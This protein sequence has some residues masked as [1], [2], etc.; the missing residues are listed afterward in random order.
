MFL[1][2]R[3]FRPVQAVQDQLAKE[4][5][6]RDADRVHIF[7]ALVVHDVD[8][9]AAILL[10][11]QVHV[12]PYFNKSLCSLDEHPSVSPGPQSVR[13]KP[14]QLEVSR[15]SVLSG[16]LGVAEVFQFRIFRMVKVR[17]P[18]GGHDRV[19][20]LRVVQELFK[21]MAADIAQDSAVLLPFKEPCGPSGCAKPVGTESGYGNHLADLSAFR[22]ISGQ[23]GSLVM[24][25]LR[26]V[27]HV[28]LSG[29][30]HC[31]LCG[32][33]LFQGCKRRLVGK[34]VFA[35]VHGPQSQG[36]AF[37]GDSRTG[38]QMRL[39]V[40]QGFFLAPGCLRLRKCLQEGFNLLLIRIIYIFERAAGLGQAVAH[41]V[42]M[43]V[44][45]PYCGKYEFS[46][47]YHRLGL[48]FRRIVHSV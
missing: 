18:A 9:S 42:N 10:R 6:S 24:Q 1:R 43:A 47:F 25:P 21:L 41:P 40:S 16:Q 15:R 34:V 23:D 37:A 8:V 39:R 2:H 45:Q 13:G 46:R 30:R 17:D 33:Q 7:F 27:H 5:I 38:N 26:V 11:R 20:F 22:D 31:F 19:F 29:F 12:F 32:F 3:V 44:V 28:L 36:A 4:R 48:P 14:I 35:R